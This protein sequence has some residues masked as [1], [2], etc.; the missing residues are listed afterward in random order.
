M[1]QKLK[2]SR[3]VAVFSLM[4]LKQFN[5]HPLSQIYTLF[6]WWWCWLIVFVC[7]FFGCLCMLLLKAFFNVLR[8]EKI[9]IIKVFTYF[10]NIYSI[11][12]GFFFLFHHIFFVAWGIYCCYEASLS[13]LLDKTGFPKFPTI[14]S[15]VYNV[16]STKQF[17]MQLMLFSV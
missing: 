13:C 10:E 12:K 8:V 6:M 2:L 15:M 17:S 4:G 3:Y 7:I 16:I 5:I 11:L 1:Y 14:Y 9:M